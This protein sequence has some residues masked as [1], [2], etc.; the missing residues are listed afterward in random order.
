MSFDDIAVISFLALVFRSVRGV[1]ATV[2]EF[3]KQIITEHS[4]GHAS[5]IEFV[6]IVIS[7]SSMCIMA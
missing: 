3:E 1:I 6:Y 5:L 2:T 4:G 7:Q